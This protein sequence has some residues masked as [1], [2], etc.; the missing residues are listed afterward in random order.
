MAEPREQVDQY[1]EEIM[2]LT[3]RL[4]VAAGRLFREKGCL[5]LE[6]VLPG[7]GTCAMNLVEKTIAD[8]ITREQWVPGS[9]G[10]DPYPLAYTALKRDF[11]DLIGLEEYKTT[12][13]TES[14]ESEYGDKAPSSNAG[15]DQADA[16]LLVNSL[17]PFFKQDKQVIELLE[18]WL[19][20]GFESRVDIAREMGITVQDVTNIKRRLISKKNIIWERLWQRKD[21]H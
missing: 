9:G 15:F 4:A 17:R 20:K 12:T 11:L 19:I 6:A 7:T 14:I 13:I 3:E 21:Q 10:E 16:A 18:V 1:W 5:D 2:V 8:L